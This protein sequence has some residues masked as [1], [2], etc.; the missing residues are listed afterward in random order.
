LIELEEKY[1]E[2]KD[3]RYIVTLNNY[4][5]LCCRGNNKKEGKMMF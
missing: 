5:E 2:R 1:L 4:A 3:E